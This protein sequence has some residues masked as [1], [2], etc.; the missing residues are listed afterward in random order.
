MILKLTNLNLF[1]LIDV[2]HRNSGFLRQ[3]TQT[4]NKKK[5]TILNKKYNN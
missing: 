1:K 2:Y 5:S 4:N 3:I